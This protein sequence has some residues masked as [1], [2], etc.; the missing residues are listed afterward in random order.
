VLSL[1]EPLL[2]R[3]NTLWMDNFLMH[4]HWLRYWNQW[5]LTVGTLRI[6]RKDVPKAV[7]D[8]KLKEEELIAQH[9]AF[10]S[11][12]STGYQNWPLEI[13]G[14]S[15]ASSPRWSWWWGRKESA[16]ETFQRQ[17]CALTN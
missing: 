2:G 8:K 9:S 10:S 7:K 14:G 4:Q 17:D 11:A 6:N 12:N 3:G 16:R 5:R 15:S 1:V 13:Q